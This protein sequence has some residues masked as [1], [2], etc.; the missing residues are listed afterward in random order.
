MLNRLLRQ[1]LVN[2][3]VHTK[4]LERRLDNAIE[5]EGKVDQKGETD[6]LEPLERL[7]A[8]T[9]GDDPDEQCSTSVD[10]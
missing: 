7:P 1:Q 4:C 9:E 2:L 10:S 5:E 8:Q 6:N 3:L